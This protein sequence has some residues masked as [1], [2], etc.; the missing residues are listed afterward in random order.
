MEVGSQQPRYFE[1]LKTLKIR[2]KLW[3]VTIKIYDLTQ[4]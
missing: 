4:F 1:T 3:I 2:K